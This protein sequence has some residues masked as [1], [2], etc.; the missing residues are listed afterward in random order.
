MTAIGSHT[1]RL[2]ELQGSLRAYANGSD[3]SESMGIITVQEGLDDKL[4]PSSFT[5]VK[6][7]MNLSACSLEYS[8]QSTWGQCTAEEG[9]DST[10]CQSE[11]VKPK[12]CAYQ[13]LSEDGS[14]EELDLNST[15]ASKLRAVRELAANFDGQYRA[16]ATLPSLLELFRYLAGERIVHYLLNK[17]TKPSFVLPSRPFVRSII[18]KLNRQP[19]SAMSV[20]SLSRDI[21]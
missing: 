12:E 13:Y 11:A 8:D 15:L 3:G 7:V 1:Q 16:N 4:S 20:T 14:Y 21:T 5:L 9:G 6:A 18:S 2:R 10:Q 17:S 19:K